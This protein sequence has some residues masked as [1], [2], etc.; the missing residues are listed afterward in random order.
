[1]SSDFLTVCQFCIAGKT[2]WYVTIICVYY[3]R[4]VQQNVDRIRLLLIIW[5]DMV[6]D[7]EDWAKGVLKQL[8]VVNT[9]DCQVFETEQMEFFLFVV[10]GREIRFKGVANTLQ[11]G[12][13]PSLTYSY[14]A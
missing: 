10:G 2:C 12:D 6:V 11:I 5:N 13:Y 1:M 3:F 4:S 14:L 8:Q 9:K 7:R